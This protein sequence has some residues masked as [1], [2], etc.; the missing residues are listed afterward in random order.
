MRAPF[1]TLAI[2]YKISGTTPLYCILHRSDIDQWQFIAGGG[3]DDETPAEAAKREIYEESGINA[4]NVFALRSMC[5]IPANIFADRHLYS[6]SK[7]TYV[8][9]EYTFAFECREDITLSDEHTEC[10]FTTYDDALAYLRWYSNKTA[11]YEL[12]QR[13]KS[14]II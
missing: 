13:L 8:I 11:L 6:W 5:Y 2:P 10:V 4:D 9:P 1:Q 3:E 14:G 7:D 12:D